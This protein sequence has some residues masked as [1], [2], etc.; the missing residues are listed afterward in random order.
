MIEG[1]SQFNTWFPVLTLVL[2]AVLKGLGDVVIEGRKARAERE[3][4]AEERKDAAAARWAQFQRE[5]LLEL[6]D[7]AQAL[8]RATGR[9]HHD[10]TMAYRHT[11]V[12]GKNKVSPE[13]NDGALD[14]HT[15]LAKFLVRVDDEEVRRLARDL[16]TACASH[17]I[18]K[19][20]ADAQHVM[21]Q[22]IELSAQL[23][24]R[25]GELLRRT[26]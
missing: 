7:A 24:E 18:S 10:D 26:A 2:G 13:A 16:S 19:S 1:A 8:A 9:A 12:W 11:G 6:Q 4:R 3:A 23:H 17:A 5:A 15:K 21:G 25:I 20:E 22:G 14:G